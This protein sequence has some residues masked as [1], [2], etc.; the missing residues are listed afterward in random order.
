MAS[1]IKNLST[2]SPLA[3]VWDAIRDVGALH[4]RLVAGFVV[5]TSLEQDGRHVTFANGMTIIEPIVTIDDRHHRLVWTA[6][7]GMSS[8]YNGALHATAGQHGGTDVS[9]IVDVLP[10]EL[11]TTIA[12]NMEAGIEAM[13]R[14]LD[15][16]AN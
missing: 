14:T 2:A 1:I 16:L 5:A 6:R 15:R 8:H 4:T 10:D 3:A 9:W 13:Q 12:S 7:G 11:A